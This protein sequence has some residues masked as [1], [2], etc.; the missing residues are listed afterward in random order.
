MTTPV[1][2]NLDFKQNEALNFVIQ[3]L[4][5][6][7]SSPVKG[8]YYFNT[9][10]NKSYFW[11]GTNW[12]EGTQIATDEEAATGTAVD[13]AVN[14]KQLAESLT[15]KQDALGFVPENSA[16]K[17]ID[18]AE[19]STD[20]QYPSAKAVYTRLSGKADV[21][22]PEFTG[23]PKAPTAVVGT[24]TTQIASTEF[25]HN[26][27]NNAFSGAVVYTGV[28]DTTDQTDYSNLN[29][30]RPIAKG[31][32]FRVAGTGCTI[33]SV[34]YL[35]GDA[36]IFNRTVA[37]GMAITTAAIDKYDNTESSD[38][39]YLAATQTLSNKTISADSNTISDLDVAN[40]KESA[41]D[42][43]V[44]SDSDKLV[45]SGAVASALVSKANIAS[46]AF[47]G[48]PTAPTAAEGTKDTQIATTAFVAAAIEAAQESALSKE[49]YTNP[50]LNPE[51]G[52]C[53]WSIAHT[54]GS[55]DILSI[56]K[57]VSTG[58][59]VIVDKI[60]Q[61]STAFVIR[62]NSSST[63]AAGTYKAL[64]IK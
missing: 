26:V 15:G 34:E 51:E 46:P 16:N 31:A 4:S 32:L 38:T 64:L 53:T 52:V 59:E 29:S 47:T 13:V 30:F 45:K 44:T 62:I 36:I 48:T 10:T 37:D 58:K 61:S 22:S 39:V 14:P 11:N 6:A 50:T 5:S 40:F 42:S 2:T 12:V 18:V 54:L 56:V 60:A 49:V 57:E 27:V 17:V 41:I 35:A 63:I 19:E 8:Q 25:V 33:D 20:T 7:P 43:T 9:T 1:E 28:W 3:R 24:N 21:A 23:V 55:T